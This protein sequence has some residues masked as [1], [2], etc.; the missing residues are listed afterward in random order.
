MKLP[1]IKLKTLA[2]AVDYVTSDSFGDQ[3]QESNQVLI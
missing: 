1:I 2:I 3:T